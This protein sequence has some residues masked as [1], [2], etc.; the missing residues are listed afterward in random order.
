M[1]SAQFLVD[2][3][4]VSPNRLRSV[5]S[6]SLPLLK[7]EGRLSG[8]SMLPI[9]P[10]EL[11]SYIISLTLDECR[12]HSNLLPRRCGLL[13]RRY[14]FVS[15]IW[16][17]LALKRLVEVVRLG[18]RQVAGFRKS[19]EKDQREGGELAAMC[20]LMDVRAYYDEAEGEDEDVREV[21]LLC[22]RIEELWYEGCQL[23][24]LKSREYSY[25]SSLTT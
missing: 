8:L 10:P 21:L 6:V 7:Q 16:R 3:A 1:Y 13:T 4:I 18:P 24:V 15:P 14:S 19:L 11:I 12:P 5:S 25:W 9:L 2:D 20:R 22:E 23:P 17:T